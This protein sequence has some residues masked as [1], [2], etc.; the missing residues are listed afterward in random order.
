MTSHVWQPK[1]PSKFFKHPLVV[2]YHPGG[3]VLGNRFSCEPDAHLFVKNFGAVVIASNYRR[4]HEYVFPKSTEDAWDTLIWATKNFSQF[5]AD[6]KDGFIIGG[7]SAGGNVTAVMQLM[8]RDEGLTPPLTGSIISVPFVVHTEAVP[9]RWRLV[10]KSFDAHQTAPI[11]PRKSITS[12]TGT[13]D[14]RASC[15][16]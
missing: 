6:P 2:L 8:A 14:T 7:M 15:A 10:Y 1:D 13:I 12:F 11:I 9:D 3:F 4:G 16:Q 5:G